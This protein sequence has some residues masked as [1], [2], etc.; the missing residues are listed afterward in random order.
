M[1]TANRRASERTWRRRLGE[2]LCAALIALAP[3]TPRPFSVDHRPV[4]V[5]AVGE[6]TP[7]IG[8]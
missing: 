6:P 2:A 7:W 3:T 4:A 8:R 5:L 1:G